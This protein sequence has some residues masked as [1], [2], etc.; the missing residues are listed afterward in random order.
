M[1]Q[2]V[3]SRGSFYLYLVIQ[4]EK[5][6]H[7]SNL[8]QNGPQTFWLPAFNSFSTKHKR[9]KTGTG[10]NLLKRRIQIRI[11]D[12]TYIWLPGDSSPARPRQLPCQAQHLLKAHCW[13]IVAMYPSCEWGVTVYLDLLNMF[14]SIYISTS[15]YL[16]L[17]VTNYDLYSYVT[18]K[19]IEKSPYK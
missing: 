4:P 15:M 8:T 9:V 17:F 3:A 14:C 13:W 19:T 1:K 2:T 12:T 11:S 10:P 16:S 18:D 7:K 5:T 6:T